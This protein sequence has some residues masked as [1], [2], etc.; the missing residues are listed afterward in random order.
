M[1]MQ[2]HTGAHL[3]AE[4]DALIKG[5]GHY[6]EHLKGEY[7]KAEEDRQRWR[8]GDKQNLAQAL[9]FDTAAKDAWD[10]I[11]AI[12][13]AISALPAASIEAAAL[14]VEVLESLVGEES[15][16]AIWARRRIH[17]SLL[18]VLE[19]TTAKDSAAN[20]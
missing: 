12:R 14:Q 20:A 11:T 6:L 2:N 13:S 15:D 9:H 3:S 8:D 4:A 5:M 19:L 16:E 10:R 1:A 7:K 18:R 17:Q